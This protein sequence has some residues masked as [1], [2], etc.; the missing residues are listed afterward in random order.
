[1]QPSSRGIASVPHPKPI[2][3]FS[4]LRTSSPPQDE[5]FGTCQNNKDTLP[6]HTYFAR[7]FKKKEEIIHSR[8][9]FF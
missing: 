9:F 4:H 1:M 3:F 7:T 2:I 5:L 6:P 8:F